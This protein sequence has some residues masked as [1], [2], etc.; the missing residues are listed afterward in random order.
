MAL[1]VK[2]KIKVKLPLQTF[3]F[4]NIYFFL[5]V[6]INYVYNRGKGFL[7]VYRK[8]NYIR[9]YF[10]GYLLLHDPILLLQ[11]VKQNQMIKFSDR[12]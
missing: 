11:P 7:F 9:H 2:W 6:S 8:A 12:R 4:P 5:V 3:F 1:K 10:I